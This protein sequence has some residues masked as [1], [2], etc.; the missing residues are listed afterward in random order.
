MELIVLNTG[1]HSNGYILNCDN[2]A[3]FIE[4]GRHYA[5]AI[6]AISHD[7]RKV[8]GCIVTHEHGD[9]ARYINEYLNAAVPVWAT[10]GTSGALR[11]AGKLKSTFQPHECAARKMFTPGG[12]EIT[13]FTVEHD[14]VEPVG[15]HIW[16][17]EMG[18]VVFATDTMSLKERFE[19]PT[20]VMIECNYTDEA[21]TANRRLPST[22]K[23]RVRSSHMSL[24]GCKEALKR[25]NLTSCRNIILIHLSDDNSEED[26]MVEEVFSA[27]GKPTFAATATQHYDFNLKPF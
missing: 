20:H 2:E 15:F 27:T 24:A 7:R 13:P 6:K 4:C 11:H 9:H 5:E 23:D 19:P 1:S 22:V 21:L 3:L 26:R 8:V 25:M 10:A 18:S 17:R 12:F 16:H 14:A